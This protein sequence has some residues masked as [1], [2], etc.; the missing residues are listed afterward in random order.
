MNKYDIWFSL[1]KLP[2]KEKLYLLKYFNSTENIWYDIINR[3]KDSIIDGKIKLYL[4]NSW[5]KEKIDNMY[6]YCMDNNIK[7][8]KLNDKNYPEKLKHYDSSPSIL[9]YK[10]D[11]TKI[12]KNKNVAIV[13]ARR[14]SIYGKNICSIIS[15]ELSKNNINIISGLAKGID[16]ISHKVCLSKEGYTCAILGS[17]IDIIYPKENKYLYNEI[18]EKGCVI[19]EFPLGTKPLKRNFPMRNRIISGISDIVI[20]VE[21]GEKSGSLITADFALDQGKD[22]MSVPGSLFSSKSKGTNKLIKEGAYPVTSIKDIFELLNYE[23]TDK[24]INKDNIEIN[25][26]EKKIYS[27]IDYSPIHI[28]DIITQSKVDI[29]QLYELLFELQFKN[30]VTC[31]SGNYYVRIKKTI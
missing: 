21:A 14:C 10:G 26:L 19:S 7:L 12:N 17:G 4:K 3:D 29:K 8:V 24:S 2:N 11:I 1:L 22:V 31:I 6:Q 15:E 25:S 30:L 27:L 5:E 28:D 13:G 18:C 23:Y 20:V 16:C 9:F